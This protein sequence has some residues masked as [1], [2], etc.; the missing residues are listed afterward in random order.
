[1]FKLFEEYKILSKVK[2]IWIN[3]S[4]SGVLMVSNKK[5]KKKKSEELGRIVFPSLQPQKSE[6]SILRQKVSKVWCQY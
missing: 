3:L 4:V 6:S 2:K 5:K 1:M